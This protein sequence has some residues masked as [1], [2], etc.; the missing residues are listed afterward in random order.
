MIAL[1][2]ATVEAHS[3]QW[4]S[5]CN[6]CSC[7]DDIEPSRVRR[8]NRPQICYTASLEDQQEESFQLEAKS[9][10]L[11]HRHN[12]TAAVTL[13]RQKYPIRRNTCLYS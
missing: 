7:L 8:C 10:K 6:N 1:R 5:R 4:R 13:I 3:L 12:G 2:S 9:S 11:P